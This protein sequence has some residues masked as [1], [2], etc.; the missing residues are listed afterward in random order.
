MRRSMNFKY[1]G[2]SR[3]KI[4]SI[5]LGTNF[6]ANIQTDEKKLIY[7]IQKALDNNIN[8]FD[9]AEVYHTGHSEKLIG[10]ALKKKRDKVIIATK[11]SPEHSGYKDVL[12]AAEGSLKRLQ[13]SYIDLYQTHWPNPIVPFEET[14]KALEK[15]IKTGKVKHIGVSNV[16]L[17]QL[18]NI[19]K[20]SKFPIVSLQTEYNLLERSAEVD[21]LP[22]CEK[23]KI[24]IIAYTPLNSGNILKLKKYSKIFSNLSKKY[25]RGVSQIILNFLVSHSSVVAI[26]ATTDVTHLEENAQSTDFVMEKQDIQLL[27]KAFAT[28]IT[29]IDTA[30][31]R[32]AIL[33]NHAAYQTVEEALD[34]K[35]NLFPSPLMLSEDIKKGDFL[36]AVRVR[37]LKKKEGNFEYELVGGRIRYWAYVLAYNGKKPIPA[38]VED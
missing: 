15:L 5:G 6:V 7:L 24:T 11:F 3:I 14:L 34:N 33:N 2:K 18:K 32:V 29:N 28:K 27:A 35:L 23:N 12:K 16:S 30:K 1:L 13:T 8:F 31:I 4:S 17:R 26:P 19:K 22:F 38:I 36:K 25:N 37:V 21:L 20:T 10:K 9:T